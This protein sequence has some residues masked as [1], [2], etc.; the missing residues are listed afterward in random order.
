MP[1]KQVIEETKAP[2]KA[3][4]SY[5]WDSE[6]HKERVFALANTLRK[7]WGIEAD[8]DEYVRAKPPYTPEQ[9]WDL[10]MEKRIEWA[11]FVLIVCTE[12]YKR[13]FRGDEEPGIGRGST[14][15][16]TIIRQHLYNNQ[17]RNTKFIPVVFS[18]QDLIHVPSI[19]N[20]NDKYVLEEEKSFRELCY[21]LRKE[22]VVA[23]PDI[24]TAKLQAP[25]EPKFFSP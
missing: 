7:P 13:R 12:T 22:P 14:W 18:A 5:S 23:I 1:E 9:G 24:A 3:F 19:L 15:E 11:E 10:W 8:M 20:G 2:T 6:D 21:R 4:I 16:G 17:M 25:L